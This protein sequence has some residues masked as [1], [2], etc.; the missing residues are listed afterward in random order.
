MPDELVYDPKTKRMI[1]DQ[2][3][4]FLYKPVNKDF[5]RRLK[6]IIVKNAN[7]HG[8]DQAYISY[9][10]EYYTFD[11]TQKRRRPVNRLKPELQ[12]LMDEYLEDLTRLNDKEIPYTLGFII[13][14]LNSSNSIQDYFRLFPESMHKPLKELLARCACREERLKQETVDDI[15]RRN[16]ISIELMKKRMVL[17]L[18]V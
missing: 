14:V 11:E 12:T 3:F 9:R 2:I 18:L 6:T 16:S 15:K 17:N 1:R 4:D 7:L 8:N 13:Q 5:A 10:G